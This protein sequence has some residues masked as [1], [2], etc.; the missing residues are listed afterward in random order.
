MIATRGSAARHLALNLDRLPD[1]E[2]SI[3]F[4]AR[5]LAPIAGR[6]PPRSL[7]H[8]GAA[9]AKRRQRAKEI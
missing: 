6:L 7:S 3:V 9:V 5:L 8:T 2:G 4:V 1:H